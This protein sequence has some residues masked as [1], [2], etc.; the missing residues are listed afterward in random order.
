LG[1]R[2]VTDFNL[3]TPRSEIPSHYLMVS[4]SHCDLSDL[5]KQTVKLPSNKLPNTLLNSFGVVHNLPSSLFHSFG[6][7]HE[8]MMTVSNTLFLESLIVK[9]LIYFH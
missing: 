6:V 4:H 7:V 9:F 8:F 2:G 3:G 5:N 1:K